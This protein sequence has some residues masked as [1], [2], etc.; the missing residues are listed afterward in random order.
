[1]RDWALSTSPWFSRRAGPLQDAGDG[2]IFCDRP[3]GMTSFSCTWRGASGQ[4][5]V[6]DSSCH[7]HPIFDR[8]FRIA[9]LQERSAAR[10]AASTAGLRSPRRSESWAT[11]SIGTGSSGRAAP[12]C[13]NLKGFLNVVELVECET[14]TVERFWM[15][16][17]LLEGAP[18][19]A[20]AFSHSWSQAAEWPSFMAFWRCLLVRDDNSFLLV[21]CGCRNLTQL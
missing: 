18:I 20:A 7:T 5:G 15:V 17:R 10:M 19:G 8:F 12:H 21:M 14:K 4:S 3:A 6:R 13:V 11:F 16:R 9:L 2:Q 1:M